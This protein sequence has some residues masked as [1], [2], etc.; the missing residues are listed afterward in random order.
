MPKP[1]SD[2][3]I[4][5]KKNRHCCYD[6]QYHMV[7]VTKHRKPVIQGDVET[8]LHEIIKDLLKSFKCNLVEANSE[9]D[10]IHIL[11]EAPP[12]VTLSVLA[13]NLKTVTARRLRK[14]FPEELSQYYWEPYFW[15]ESY[16]VGSVSERTKAVVQQYIQN[17]KG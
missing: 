9:P 6:L 17:Q 15:S 16:F 11:F 1:K 2:T 14:E 12:Q 8:R 5:Y 3:E 10:H 4:L 13:N 7:F